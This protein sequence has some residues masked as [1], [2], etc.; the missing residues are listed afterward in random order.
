MSAKLSAA[1]I[2]FPARRVLGTGLLTRALAETLTLL[3][4]EVCLVLR[5]ISFG[6][7]LDGTWLDAVLVESDANEVGRER[8]RMGVRFFECVGAIV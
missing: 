1:T 2:R 5:L 4:R 7:L 3:R 6:L 8:A